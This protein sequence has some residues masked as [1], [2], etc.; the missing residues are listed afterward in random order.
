MKRLLWKNLTIPGQQALVSRI[1]LSETRG[2]VLHKHDFPEVF[3]V[4]EGRIEYEMNGTVEELAPH[5]LVLIKPLIDT[6]AYRVTNGQSAT[7]I[8]VAFSSKILRDFARRYFSNKFDFWSRMESDTPIICMN[9]LQTNFLT[10]AAERLA[11]VVNSRFETDFFIFNLLKE[12]AFKNTSFDFRRCPKWLSDACYKMRDPV[13]LAGG[14]PRLTQLAGRTAEHTARVLKSSI[15]KTPC[16][17]VT[18]YRLEYASAQLR[19][20]N[21]SIPEIS[22]ECGFESLSHFYRIFKE[23]FGISPGKYRKHHLEAVLPACQ[24]TVS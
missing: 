1:T 10:A 6:H 3:W 17:V 4:E 7:F 16:E 9:T 18:T 11:E 12:I 19:I 22:Y 2:V 23:Q 20:T 5:T 14:V 24:K 21:K 15:G 8:N 13:N